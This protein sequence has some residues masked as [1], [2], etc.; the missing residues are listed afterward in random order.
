M[1]ETQNC[2]AF[3]DVMHAKRC[4]S[5]QGKK[6]TLYLREREPGIP[7]VGVGRST[8]MIHGQYGVQYSSGKQGSAGGGG[9]ALLPCLP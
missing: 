8:K 2:Y 7:V 3:P 6:S 4:F 1:Q 9:P 5:K